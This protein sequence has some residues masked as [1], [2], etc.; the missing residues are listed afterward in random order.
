MHSRG[1]TVALLSSL[2]PRIP[3]RALNN[4]VAMGNALRLSSVDFQTCRLADSPNRRGVKRALEVGL[5]IYAAAVKP[6][7]ILVIT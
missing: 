1:L 5:E 7:A 6:R 4:R 2:V 3:E